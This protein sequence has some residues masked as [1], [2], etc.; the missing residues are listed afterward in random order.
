MV[1]AIQQQI[2]E[3]APVALRIAG[4]NDPGPRATRQMIGNDSLEA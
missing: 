3:R 2:E 1:H 4:N